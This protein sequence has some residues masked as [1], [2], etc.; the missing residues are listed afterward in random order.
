MVSDRK[1]YIQ[2]T[3]LIVMA[4][5]PTLV[6]LAL[7]QLQFFL[8]MWLRSGQSTNRNSTDSRTACTW[9]LYGG[10]LCSPGSELIF[11]RDAGALSPLPKQN[12]VQTDV[13]FPPGIECFCTTIFQNFATVFSP[14][15]SGDWVCPLM[16]T[17]RSLQYFSPRL[18]NLNRLFDDTHA[19]IESGRSRMKRVIL[20]MRLQAAYQWG[21]CHVFK[22][23]FYK[24][25]PAVVLRLLVYVLR[26]VSLTRQIVLPKRQLYCLKS[27]KKVKNHNQTWCD[28]SHRIFVCSFHF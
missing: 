5:L 6:L 8:L 9:L 17:E 14:R 11:V 28:V 24:L 3:L 16:W 4:S 15:Q 10:S 13:W 23:S 20:L 1:G 18:N 26:F 21:V 27:V 22:G 7:L 25:R 12:N 19:I 2:T